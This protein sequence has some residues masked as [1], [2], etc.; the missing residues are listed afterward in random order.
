MLDLVLAARTAICPKRRVRVHLRFDG[1]REMGEPVGP[2]GYAHRRAQHPTRAA[3]PARSDCP[4]RPFS[5]ANRSASA[6]RPFCSR[7]SGR[8]RSL[9]STLA[10]LLLSLS[11]GSARCPWIPEPGATCASDHRDCHSFDSATAGVS[12]GV[13]SAMASRVVVRAPTALARVLSP[14]RSS[15]KTNRTPARRGY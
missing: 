15:S 4:R 11:T 14:V 7:R 10:D 9:A 2:E 3:P 6:S 8:L 5:T 13:T 12:R 1:D